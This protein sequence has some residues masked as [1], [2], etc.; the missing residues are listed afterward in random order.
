MGWSVNNSELSVHVRDVRTSAGRA[1]AA[2]FAGSHL[3]RIP[4]GVYERVALVRGQETL[5]G[6]HRGVDVQ[7]LQP[8]HVRVHAQ[9]I[10]LGQI[11]EP[12]RHA[13]LLGERHAPVREH[14]RRHGRDRL[15]QVRGRHLGGVRLRVR[16]RDGA[17]LAATPS[18]ARRRVSGERRRDAGGCRC[19][20]RVPSRRANPNRNESGRPRVATRGRP[21]VAGD[22]RGAETRRNRGKHTERRSVRARCR[23]RAECVSRAR[24][25][26]RRAADKKQTRFCGI[27]D[28]LRTSGSTVCVSVS[29]CETNNN[30]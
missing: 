4:R 30:T 10:V 7:N 22:A 15:A 1:R 23:D 25:V 5:H 11:P 8:G 13:G 26:Q 2:D 9:E 28:I 24:S 18:D 20:P 6:H 3:A 27:S 16:S 19:P 21:D 12:R 14:F 29:Q 17:H